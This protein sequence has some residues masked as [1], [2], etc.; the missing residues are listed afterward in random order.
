MDFNK[1]T[2]NIL[3]V[4]FRYLPIK[5]QIRLGRINKQ[6][7]ELSRIALS[8][9]KS[10]NTEQLQGNKLQ[11]LLNLAN[12]CSSN[13]KEIK[14]GQNLVHWMP[15]FC[16]IMFPKLTKLFVSV[17]RRITYF[18][19]I[20]AK[21]PNL[22]SVKWF[23]KNELSWEVSACIKFPDNVVSE[24]LET[25]EIFRADADTFQSMTGKCP[26]LRRFHILVIDDNRYHHSNQFHVQAL[27]NFDNF[28][29][30]CP[31]LDSFQI[32]H[33]QMFSYKN[34]DHFWRLNSIRCLTLQCYDGFDDSDIHKISTCFP[35]LEH[36]NLSWLNL[37]NVG[38]AD[39]ATLKKIKNMRLSTRSGLDQ[40]ID[41][42]IR[43][44][45]QC[46]NLETLLIYA[47]ITSTTLIA[48]FQHCLQF[49]GLEIESLMGVDTIKEAL[50][51]VESLGEIV[52]RDVSIVTYKQ[53]IWESKEVPE[54]LNDL[55]QAN[56]HVIK[57]NSRRD[58]DFDYSDSVFFIL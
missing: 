44:L 35:Q 25:L 34:F 26:N 13:L 36:L 39:L 15:R 23:D 4:I 32:R 5:D 43:L 33:D 6:F 38:L 47:S 12:L 11:S 2:P 22:E 7:Q 48:F 37:T 42:G 1:L 8:E 49:R 45:T 50:D 54:R 28:F 51:V 24:K 56:G 27:E 21:S 16:E 40:E 19:G 9:T 14:I 17:N 53:E 29:A 41:L 57:I 18:G 52:T 46:Q 31:N 58:K 30:S 55:E 20:I 10:I 3:L